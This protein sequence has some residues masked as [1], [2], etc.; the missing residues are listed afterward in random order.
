MGGLIGTVTVEKDGL[1]SKEEYA[2]KLQG[3]SLANNLIYKIAQMSNYTYVRFIGG[4]SGHLLS[5]IDFGV[6]KGISDISVIGQ[7]PS[8]VSLKKGSDNSIYVMVPSGET[9][10]GILLGNAVIAIERV[11]QFPSDSIDLT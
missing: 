11:S 4:S 5:I 3:I 10:N 8:F 7:K 6:S 1:L 9:V 2:R